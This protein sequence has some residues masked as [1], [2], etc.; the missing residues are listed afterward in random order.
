MRPTLRD[1]SPPPSASRDNHV[2]SDLTDADR[3]TLARLEASLWR[4]DT[5]FDRE[6]MENLLATEFVE[7]GRSG[8]AYNRAEILEL[9]PSLINAVLRDLTIQPLGSDVALATYVSELRHGNETTLAN[10]SSIWIRAEGH[11][12][13]RFHQGTPTSA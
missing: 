7:F 5:R 3:D 4:T 6:H 8:R 2:M 12:Q 10:R 13:L 11:W 1:S 9:E